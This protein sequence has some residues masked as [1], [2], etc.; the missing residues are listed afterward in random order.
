MKNIFKI[1]IAASLFASSSLVFA[2][3]ADGTLGATSTGTSDVSLTIDEKFQISGMD[4]FS[5][6]SWS[7]TGD[8]DANN[9]MCIYHNGD[10][11]Y[12]ITFT[13]NSAMSSGFAVENA[14][15]TTEIPMAVRFIAN[16][17]PTGNALMT[18]NTPATQAAAS[19]NIAATNCGGTDNANIQVV[20]TDAD[21][22]GAPAGAYDSE[23]TVLVDPD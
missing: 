17:S 5:F 22:S 16:I 23:I 11:S 12:K 1:A 18:Y 6:G 13:D 3:T 2:A 15:D 4:T 19:A 20:L 21:L 7:G 9:S 10:G 8:L 14:A